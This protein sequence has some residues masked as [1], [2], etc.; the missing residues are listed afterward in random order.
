MSADNAILIL[1][2]RDQFRV[3]EAAAIENLHWSWENQKTIGSGDFV[4]ARVFEYFNKAKKFIE[5]SEA[6]EYA[7]RLYSKL[8]I[9]EYGII[10]IKVEKSWLQI[11]KES[12]DQLNSEKMFVLNNENIRNKSY[13]VEEINYAY[14][15]V[16]TALNGEKYAK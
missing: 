13:I 1:S 10:P 14:S 9:C 11:L 7:S 2:L 5:K 4:S 12:R 16:L 8:N 3:T 6:Y 15:D